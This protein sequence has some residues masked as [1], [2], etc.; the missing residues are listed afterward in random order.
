MIEN[1]K[2][3]IFLTIKS[4]IYQYFVFTK[5][6]LQRFVSFLQNFSAGI[7]EIESRKPHQLKVSL[8]LI[9]EGLKICYFLFV[10]NIS[11][12]CH[13]VTQF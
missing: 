5:N 13:F 7:F 1:V 9:F 11:R 8:A 4:K 12:N 3:I 10:K 2:I 6:I